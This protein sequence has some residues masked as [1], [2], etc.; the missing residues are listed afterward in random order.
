MIKNLLL[1]FLAIS[2]SAQN[3]QKPPQDIINTAP[4]WAQMMYEENPNI[5]NVDKAYRAY[6]RENDFKKDIHTQ[7]YKK[8]RRN[9]IDRI[10]SDGNISEHSDEIFQRQKDILEAKQNTSL[11]YGNW[12][13]V[14]PILTHS[15]GGEVINS[16]S[17]VYCIDQSLVNSNILYCGTES[18]EVYKSIDG[19]ENWF[20]VSL[21]FVFGTGINLGW[22]GLKALK[23]HPTNPDI[24]YISAGRSIYKT[25]DGGTHWSEIYEAPSSGDLNAAEILIHPTQSNMV[26]LVGS[27]GVFRSLD[28][29]VNW[30][31]IYT[32][33]SYDIKLNV[34][35][36]NIIYLL[37]KNA[38]LEICEFLIST[39]YGLTFNVQ[40]N[41]WY[42]STDPDRW[43]VGGKISVT[44][45]DP[46]RVY[47][48]LI[49]QS[50]VGDNGFIG[51]YKSTN[52]GL[53]W[54]LPNG[55][56]GSPYDFTH[57]NLAGSLPNGNGYHQGF[58]NCA[59]MTSHTDP[60]KLLIGG[61]NLLASDDGGATFYTLAGT[62]NGNV[63][64]N[65]R[66]FH[67]DMQYFSTIGNT[68]WI[69]TDGGI[70]K[71]TDFFRSM[72]FEH[73]TKGIHSAEYWGFGSGWNEDVL[74][75][76][77]YH[78]SAAVLYEN[79]GFGN[80]LVMPGG[81]EPASGYVNP[82]ENKRIYS[83]L[84]DGGI[85]PLNIIDPI[86]S[87]GFGIDPNESYFPFGSSELEFNPRCYSIAYT[88]KDNQLWKT[89]DK[90][91]TFSLLNTFG[92]DTDND[93]TEIEI[94]RADPNIIYV[95]QRNLSMQSSVL[96][97][98]Q[99]GGQSWDS[100]PLPNINFKQNMLLQLDPI[101]PL[102][103]WIAFSDVSAP[104]RVFKTIDG[105]TNWT[106]LTTATIQNQNARSLNL[107]GGTDGGVYLFTD[108]SVFYRNNNMSDWIDFSD[109]LPLKTNT[110]VAK[111]FYRDGKIRTATYGKGIWESEFYEAPLG[112][113]AQIMVDKL[114]STTNP[115]DALHS[116][117]FVDHSMLN[118][119]N[120][121]WEWTFEGGMPA[122]ANTPEVNVTFEGFGPHL[123]TL[124]VTNEN[125]QF[126]TDY[127]TITT[128]ENNIL[129]ILPLAEGFEE[130]FPPMGF[131]IVNPSA[132]DITWKLNDTVGGFGQSNKSM[133][134]RG[135]YSPVVGAVDDAE[136]TVDLTNYQNAMLTFDVAYVIWGG[137]YFEG[138]EVL[139]SVDCGITYDSL[140]FRE[141]N[142]LATAP[143][144]AST[145]FVPTAS[146]WRTD[147][148]DLSTYAGLDN[149][150]LVFRAIQ[151]Y[152]QNLYLDNINLNGDI[153]LSVE[154]T[155]LEPNR[156]LIYPNPVK[157]GN[158]LHLYSN[159][160]ESI[161]VEIYSVDGKRIYKQ[162]HISGTDIS[163]S[164]LKSGTYMYLLRTSKL[165][166]KGKFVVQ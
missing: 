35:N 32:E 77:L 119:E 14:G 148:V 3:N 82:G 100:V 39:D 103:I 25:I 164:N 158:P 127:L 79:Y 144:N 9:L 21:N 98:T 47:A 87:V 94:S 45:A 102:K 81:G 139:V 29:G 118:H 16:Q 160:E 134:L 137:S 12:S 129:D 101:D 66:D 51:L 92:D 60:D 28:A 26:F 161:I 44:Q 67:T 6:Y 33:A 138:L 114:N 42:T 71:S 19:G 143:P 4:N 123:V 61:V 62:G 135:Y 41:G 105:G 111:P 75:G 153:A 110:N 50:K 64:F 163:I 150:I 159:L 107:I 89:E 108:F 17:N 165:I 155:T 80:A 142:D 166:K 24:V 136:I 18:S 8:W 124:K 31:Q 130:G 90:G 104:S 43:A 95:C 151:G 154:E 63:P 112:P 106:N 52:G 72:N 55:P 73:K 59:L 56:T 49:G 58:Y 84:H 34:A 13:L 149:V 113:I 7:F 1:F 97:I 125:G 85:I 88:G 65:A 76:G 133:C 120:A 11:L 78:N 2:T 140:Y 83:S 145:P 57:I 5:Y 141:G 99:D 91:I 69:A 68:S 121:T 146:Q 162:I 86:L 36:D 147:S 131:E 128:S 157:S 126:D 115:C 53:T 38:S 20:N 152:G 15:E 156:L 37:K 40:S 22:G 70:Y 117:H 93:I 27:Q 116:F 10:L 96:W 132:D 23:I 48:Y 46:N 109:G 54:T 74:Y 122:T 30:T